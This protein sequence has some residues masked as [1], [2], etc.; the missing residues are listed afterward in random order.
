MILVITY[1]KLPNKDALAI[2][3]MNLA[4]IFLQCGYEPL[5]VGMGDSK[6]Q[7]TEQYGGL[8]YTSLRY[9]SKTI[10]GRL[11][12]YFGM[13]KK[14]KRL[15]RNPETVEAIIVNTLPFNTLRYIKKVCKETKA[16]LF[17]DCCEW[18]SPTQ[19][20]FGRWNINYQINRYF[21][22]N[23]ISS[24]TYPIAISKYLENYFRNKDIE[25]I[26]IPAILDVE[27]TACRKRPVQDKLTLVYAGSPG[28]KDYLKEAI[29]GLALMNR[30]ELG[31]IVF[32]I[33]GIS[34]RQL[35]ALCDVQP[36][37][38][39]LLGNSLILLGRITHEQVLKELE[40]ADFTVLLRSPILRYAKAGFPTKVVESLAAATP[41]ICN[42]TSDLGDYLID[43]Q[44]SILVGECTP[45]AFADSVRK[46]LA[47]TPEQKARMYRSARA[48]A[49]ENFDY[50]LYSE[51]V[52]HLMKKRGIAYE[53]NR[54]R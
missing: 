50:R 16:P 20:R 18:Y 27:R 42:V 24:D 29:E 4:R 38:I 17:V 35:M 41:V 26:R 44:N 3:S 53:D 23:Y 54:T 28:K 46:A 15:L 2:R 6:F 37:T 9:P 11:L 7:K 45:E 34:K 36:K 25:T 49:E 48:C 33:I 14:V 52:H 39:E 43:E 5:L 40:E 30:K 19:F 22:R 51:S 12:N 8:H 21:V 32:K 10:A 1:S 13:A 31:G 47:L